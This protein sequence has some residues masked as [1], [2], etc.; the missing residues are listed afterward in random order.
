[1][2]LLLIFQ[3]PN[4]EK[5]SPKSASTQETD[6]NPLQKSSVENLAYEKILE[7]KLR[8]W[9]GEEEVRIAWINALEE[10]TGVHFD[11]ERA[12]KD[13]SYNNIIIEFKAPGLFKGKKDS[14]KFKEAVQDRLL[15]YIIKESAKTKTPQEDFI[16]I[17]IDGDHIC[18]AQ[19]V[20]NEIY[21]EH[22]I[23]FSKASVE[24]VVQAIQS[25]FRKAVTIE[26]LQYDFGLGSKNARRF[27]QGLSDALAKELSKAGNTKI[28]MLFEEWRTLYG[29]VADMSILQAETISSELSFDWKG[30]RS[31][32]LSGRLFVIHSYNSLF[33]KLLAAEIVSSHGLSTIEFPAQKMSAGLSDDELIEFLSSQIEGSKIFEQAGIKGFVEEA[34]FSWYLE[35]ANDVTYK[36]LLIDPLRVLLASLSLY[37]TDTSVNSRDVLRDLYQ[38][39]IPGKLRQSIGEFY[40]PDWLVDLT[41]SKAKDGG[42]LEKRVLDP[43]CGSGI[44]VVTI[45]REK[46]KEAEALGWSSDKILDHI[47]KN[48]W[49]FDLNPL[50]VQTARVNFLIEIADLLEANPGFEIEI[51]ILLADAIYSPAPLPNSTDGLVNYKIG[52]QYAK[53]DIDLPTQLALNRTRLDQLFYLMGIEIEKESDFLSVK[54]Q[55]ISNKV[56]SKAEFKD[57]NESLKKTYN[58]VLDLHKKKWNGI[59]FRIVRNFF[60]S[61][62]AGTFDVLTGN[63]PWVRWSKLPDLYRERVKPTCE[64]YGIFSKTKMHGGN[65]LDISAMITYT[66]SDKW[67]KEGGR[68]A[69][70]ITGTIFKNP[71]S[72]GFRTFKI[73]P[74]NPESYYLNPVLVE[75]MKN[76]KPFEDA[77]NHTTIAVFDKTK[78]P[79]K[80]PV[81]YSEWSPASGQKRKIDKVDALPSVLKKVKI[82]EKEAMP[83]NVEGSPW[84]ILKKGRFQILK[85]FSK[86]SNIYFGRKGITTDLNGVYFVKHLADN[87]KLVQIQSRPSAGKKDIGSVRTAWVEPDLLYPLIKGAGDFEACFVKPQ[88]DEKLLA[89]V[90]N[91]GISNSD[92]S[93]SENELNSLTLRKSKAWFVQFQ[94]LL[95]KRSTYRRQ[96]KGAPFFA[97]YNVGDYAFSPWKVI[98]PE[99]SSN[100]YAAVCGSSEVPIIGT[101]PFIPD[102][103]VYY[104]AFDSSEKAYFLCGLLNCSIV[105]EWIESHNVSIQVGDIFKHLS[106]PEYDSKNTLHRRLA[107]LVELAHGII[108]KKKREAELKHVEV[109]A[110]EV[111]NSY[112]S[113][114]K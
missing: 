91:K 74:A 11:T 67:L 17:A 110:I 58:Q 18:F 51:P 37:K 112:L 76:L 29:Q 90:P 108:D 50:A 24:L 6:N 19:V 85:S 39:L 65:E 103:K 105:K 84:A 26:N 102:H 94:D 38:G 92:Y 71:S 59:W 111:L 12:K 10:S 33:I 32:F 31:Y 13:G 98:W 42:W 44:F 96:M 23:P 93:N 73:E 95:E 20:E 66:T 83:V 97:I 1:M 57:W 15:P 16:G 69:F 4:Q 100:F 63:P 78:F 75:D 54:K 101:R 30:D 60:W 79:P 45:I 43:T 82:F 87:N 53:L 28:K 35:L 81:S 9:S 72:S 36:G 48:V 47:C 3:N 62:T 104:A 34:I 106:L 40:T 68:V 25:N 14:P 2:G 113:K 49:G 114:G 21:T 61:A 7:K 41:L 77:S 89:F 22:L 5:M 86:K 64:Q 8:P 56:V 99:M 55:L 80:Y 107:E 46:R 27:L 52:S 70:V 88:S 109:K